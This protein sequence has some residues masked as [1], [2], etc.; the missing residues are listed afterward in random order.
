MAVIKRV[1]LYEFTLWG[2]D[3]VSVVLDGVRIR[4]F[5]FVEALEIVRDIEVSV[6]KRFDCTCILK[7]F[8]AREQSLY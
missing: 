3:L 8:A 5:F 1:S 6:L 7:S 2:R 4:F